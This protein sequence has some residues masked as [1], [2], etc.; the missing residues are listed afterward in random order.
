M[1]ACLPLSFQVRERR[2][3]RSGTKGSPVRLLV[4]LLAEQA[5]EQTQYSDAMVL[6]VLAAAYA[7]AGR[8]EGALITAEEAR[9]LAAM[10][11]ATRLASDIGAR[12]ALYRR[13]EAYRDVNRYQAIP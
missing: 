7:A 2:G 1:P 8:W 13:R 11:G 3:A 4:S 12:L 6:D 9:D 10:N 5:A